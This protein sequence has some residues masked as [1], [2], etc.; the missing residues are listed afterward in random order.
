MQTFMQ[1]QT[2]GDKQHRAAR[3]AAAKRR[4]S[5]VVH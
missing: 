3:S 1:F 5:A 4:N 2:E